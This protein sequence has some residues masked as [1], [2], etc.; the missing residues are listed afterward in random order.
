MMKK[1]C[2]LVPFLVLATLVAGCA[3]KYPPSESNLGFTYPLAVCQPGAIRDAAAQQRQLADKPVFDQHTVCRTEAGADFSATSTP[4]GTADVPAETCGDWPGNV[5]ADVGAETDEQRK[6]R[7]SKQAFSRQE[8]CLRQH[9]ESPF[10]TTTRQPAQFGIALSGGGSKAASFAIGVLAGLSDVQLLDRADYL[11]SVSGGGYAAYFYYAHRLFPLV[12]QGA[13]RVTASNA[14]L[15]QD[16]IPLPVTFHATDKVIHAIERSAVHCDRQGL[17]ALE[18][19]TGLPSATGG[20]QA[21][22]KC[23]Q[24]LMRPGDCSMD[25]TT[26]PRKGISLATWGGSAATFLPSLVAHTLFDWGMATSP[27][28]ISYHDGIGMAYGATLVDTRKLEPEL[29]NA[30]TRRCGEQAGGVDTVLDCTTGI[31]DPDPVALTFDELRTGLLKMRLAGGDG[32]PF[33]IMNA[34]APQHRSIYGW[35]R[36]GRHDVTNSDM[37]EMTA[38]SHGSGRY[39]YV[40]APAAIH[41]MTVLDGVQASAAFLDA[42]EL[43]IHNRLVRTAAGLGLHF[44]NLDWGLDIAN[45]NVSTRRRQIHRALPFPLYY[46]DSLV[47]R[48]QDRASMSNERRDRERSVFI[49]LID[50]GNAE[51]LGVYSLL[52]RGVRNIL[53]ADAAA[54]SKGQFPDLCGLR[55]RLRDTPA[56][57]MPRFVYFPGLAGFDEHCTKLDNGAADSGY[58][59]YNWFADHPLLLGCIRQ[60][61][62]P[63]SGA[64]QCQGVARDEVRLLVAKPAVDLAAFQ[65]NQLTDHIATLTDGSQALRSRV[66]DC[67]VRGT[68]APTA[69]LNCDTALFLHFNHATR[70]GDCPIFPQHSTVLMTA[71]SSAT[72]F[73]AYRELARQH[74]QRDAGILRSLLREG[75][76]VPAVFEEALANQARHHMLP[77]GPHCQ[78]F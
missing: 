43:V 71:N 13:Q 15:F 31:F 22:L 44:A 33:W 56:G 67:W 53:I 68:S 38:V 14:E 16:C 66:S 26:S 34:A 77:D 9:L 73:A 64:F 10:A 59:L 58:D 28:A 24:D 6:Q 1:F 49:R 57:E 62:H 39:G 74:V 18:P 8:R 3:H 69:L 37:F 51:N 54:D 11:S 5:A 42:N 17:T 25:T 32:M 29:V 48:T 76:V 55:R 60:G 23:T 41:G 30:R 72:L 70:K 46:L 47:A 7:L 19:T 52:K 75:D 36:E 40:S 63:G 4:V 61:E 45:Y 27:S 35:L 12:R 78:R 65:K 21:F 20:Y 50:G 2:R